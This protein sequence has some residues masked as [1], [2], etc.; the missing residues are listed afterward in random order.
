MN[1]PANA[2]ELIKQLRR[3][4]AH[5]LGDRPSRLYVKVETPFV[6]GVRKELAETYC[7]QRLC[8]VLWILP[9]PAR[10]YFG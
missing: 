4:C 7:G 6:T 5:F 3:D 2:F 8:Y 9:T 10:K 1:E